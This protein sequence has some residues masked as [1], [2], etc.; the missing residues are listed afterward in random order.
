MPRD[1]QRPAIETPPTH[2]HFSRGSGDSERYCTH[3]IKGCA[4]KR[5]SS[6]PTAEEVQDAAGHSIPQWDR[7]KL[8]TLTEAK[9][10]VGENPGR[11]WKQTPATEKAV[12]KAAVN[13]QLA[14]EGI[15]EVGD[16]IIRWRMG[17]AVRDVI[18][19]AKK[20]AATLSAASSATPSSAAT[21]L[22]ADPL[23]SSAETRTPFDPIRDV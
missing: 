7:F 18:K 14:K 8:F 2:G 22:S 15:P 1:S 20:K 17:L 16:A 21:P 19:Q 9:R 6:S 4:M 23:A 3:R 12:V 13:K 11:T 5:L 10:V